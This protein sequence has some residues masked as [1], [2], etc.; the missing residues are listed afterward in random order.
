MAPPRDRSFCHAFWL[1]PG[2]HALGRRLASPPFARARPPRVPLPTS[3]RVP[4]R[5]AASPRLLPGPDPLLELAPPP[6][7]PRDAADIIVPTLQPIRF[8]ASGVAESAEKGR[9]A[10][11]RGGGGHSDSEA[12]LPSTVDVNVALAQAEGRRQKT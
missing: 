6:T 3:S 12:G 10:S 1:A 5:L 2:V 9:H 8:H 7:Q 4:G 11:R